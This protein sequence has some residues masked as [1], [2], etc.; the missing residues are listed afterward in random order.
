[1]DVQHP[2]LRAETAVRAGA[3]WRD[4]QAAHAIAGID[5]DTFSELPRDQRITILAQY[6]VQWRVEALQSWE[7][8]QKRKS[9]QNQESRRTTVNARRRRYG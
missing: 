2:A 8:D 1:M 7:Q 9:K 6:E 3:A 4:A 5:Y